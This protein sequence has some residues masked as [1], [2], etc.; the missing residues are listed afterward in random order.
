MG[1]LG[2]DWEDPQSQAIMALAGGLLQGNFGKGATDYGAVLAGAKDQA[3]RR[4]MAD[5]QM[6]NMQSE[7]EQRK[8]AAEAAQRKQQLLTDM[9]SGAKPISPGAFVPS[10]DGRG[11]TM[12]PEMA[13]KQSGIG[14]LSI[15]DIAKLKA[16]GGID[17]M[18]VY[19]WANDPL[20]LEQGS[21][22]RDRITSK[23]RYMPKV[24]EGIAPDANGFYG[25]L[26]GYGAA[27]A[28]IEGTKARAVE[29]AK[30]GFD[31]VQ[32]PQSDGTNRM[33]SKAQAAQSL[34]GPPAALAP[35]KSATNRGADL[36]PELQRFLID[37]AKKEG[38]EAPVF[39]FTAPKGKALGLAAPQL[40]VS[41]SPADAG[42]QK[43]I[44]DAG[45][46]VNDAWL[47]TGYEPVI[48][49]GQAA[50]SLIDSS[51]VAREA[52]KKIGGGGWGTETK[53]A[54]AAILE[55]MG[56]APK[57][58][59]MYAANAQIF[60][61]TAMDRLWTTLNAAKGIQTEGD[62][63]RASKTWAALKNTPQAND[64]ILDLSQAQAER[65]KAKAAFFKNALPIAKENGDLSEVEREWDQRMPSIFDMP[66]MQKWGKK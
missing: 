11:P 25:E 16:L 20:K 60:Q 37:N 18:D 39:N 14:N 32:V 46:K 29:G 24:G 56:I 41:Q 40:G 58:T 31:F 15:D 34:G 13:G 35:P 52:L 63:E 30:A 43:N 12:P 26:P 21:T 44:T 38:V 23:E 10:A 49:A 9:F 5:M 54:A 1:L 6:Q 36:T 61:K 27:Q 7:M 48:L 59:A 4:K 45:G 2:N 47:K 62:A 66:T 22:Y 8:I 17:M 42:R 55:G 57:A 33:M 51:A 65:D 64:Y 19:K 28:G 3:L 53:A 50:Q